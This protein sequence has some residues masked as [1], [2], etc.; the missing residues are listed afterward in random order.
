MTDRPLFADAHW[1]A[2]CNGG[3]CVEVAFHGGWV[4]LRD[5]KQGDLGPV[6]TFTADEWDA[7]V[8]GIKDGRFETP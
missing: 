6:L 3:A 4:G 1:R 2:A 5:G 7:F 8:R